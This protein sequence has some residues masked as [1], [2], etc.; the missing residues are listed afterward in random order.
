MRSKLPKWPIFI[1]PHS[2]RQSGVLYTDKYLLHWILWETKNITV[3]KSNPCFLYSTVVGLG[4]D[5]VHPPSNLLY[6]CIASQGWK[7]DFLLCKQCS[8]TQATS[9]WFVR[10]I[11]YGLE[12]AEWGQFYPVRNILPKWHLWWQEIKR[13]TAFLT[14]NSQS[15]KGWCSSCELHWSAKGIL[16]TREKTLKIFLI[17]FIIFKEKMKL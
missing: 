3:I 10:C 9:S 5:P 8:L 16:I 2:Q 1:G 13:L 14:W 17:F 6:P 7:D 12:K 15:L 4:E 11:W